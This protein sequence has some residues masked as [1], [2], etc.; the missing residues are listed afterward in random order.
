MPKSPP[1][2]LRITAV[3]T[4]LQLSGLITLS[5]V[6]ADTLSPYRS[7]WTVPQ[8][9][10]SSLSTLALKDG[11]ISARFGDQRKSFGKIIRTYSSNTVDNVGISGRPNVSTRLN[12]S[13]ANGNQAW[14]F[15]GL[16]SS[17]EQNINVGVTAGRSTLMLST[18]EG[19]STS[20]KT[21]A[22]YGFSN[23]YKNGFRPAS[24]SYT[25]LNLGYQVAPN[26]YLNAGGSRVRLDGR[27]DPYAYYTSFSYK[28][29]SGHFS[30]TQRNGFTLAKGLQLSY[31][32][33]PIKTSYS[34]YK[35]FRDFTLRRMQFKFSNGKKGDYV[36]NLESGTSPFTG[37][38]DNRFLISYKL[39]SR[40]PGFY[41]AA[42][43]ENKEGE[44]GA[45]GQ[46]GFN[47]TAIVVGSVA[48]LAA[49]VGSSSGNGDGAPGGFPTQNGAAFSVLNGINPTSV[50]ENREYGGWVYRIGDG[51]FSSTTPV[52]GSVASVNIGDPVTSVPPGTTS[53]ASYHTHGGP[54]PRFLNEVFSSTDINLDNVQ[55][56]DGYLGTPGAKFL[57][58]N[59]LSGQITQI[60]I[61]AI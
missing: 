2:K 10:L 5:P 42:A 50:T 7:A 59:R 29:L 14:H 61:L 37:K 20:W 58:H 34:E 45:P 18:G 56:V 53:T 19:S 35:N 41:H 33:G 3:A 4:A 36:F 51:S 9:N 32:A 8:Y 52:A 1:R 44:E 48:V 21:N 26:L 6:S 17:N 57:F 38:Q 25:G 11:T 30:T 31:S 22:L 12:Y 39:T 60:G 47:T 15:S 24:Y 16:Q 54:D 23:S 49:A 13:Y 27:V 46:G 55:G 43:K 40:T 28:H